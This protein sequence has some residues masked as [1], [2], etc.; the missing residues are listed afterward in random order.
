VSTEITLA[1]LL[2]IDPAREQEFERFESS[3]ADIMSRYGGKIER[4]ISFPPADDP[5]QPHELHVVT[6][7]DRDSFDS[8][9]RDPELQDLANLRAKAIRQTVVWQG[10]DSPPF[11]G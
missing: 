1:V 8:Y 3:A 5:S 4:R 11:Q 6:F 10:V 2:F 9:R 7:P